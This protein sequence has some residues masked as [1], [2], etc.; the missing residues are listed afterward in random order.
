[1]RNA[2]RLALL[3]AF[4]VVA[5]CGGGDGNGPSDPVP[6]SLA[7]SGGNGQTGPV[8]TALPV[9][10][11][12]I[13]KD[14]RGNGIPGITVTFA[15]QAGGGTL[16]GAQV[17]TNQGG[18]AQVGS[19]I[20]GTASGAN[21]LSATVAGLTPIT[22]TATATAGPPAALV[23][24][25]APA[26][27]TANGATL[28][29]S[30]SVQVKD[31]FGNN[32]TQAGFMVTVAIA[33]GGGTLGGT[34]TVAT[35]ASGVAT[36]SNLTITGSVGVRTLSFSG[37]GV[38]ALL[39][40]NI[41]LTS[42]AAT[43][44]AA[45]TPTT[46]AGTAGAAVGSAVTVTATDQSGNPVAGAQV[47]FAVTAG[48]GSVTGASQTTDAS[49][50]A[51]L[52]SWTLGTVA[53]SLNTVSATLGALPP[54]VFSSTPTAAAPS[55]LLMV[56]EPGTIS[57]VN[58]SPLDPQPA[59]QVAD[60]FGNP[61]AQVVSVT[62]SLSGGGTLNGT[63]MLNTAADGSLSFSG[64]TVVGLNG[65]RTLGFSAPGLTGVTSAVFPITSGPA[66]TIAL[67]AGDGQSATVGTAVG[68]VPVVLITDQSGNP[69]G[70]EFVT[71]AITAGGGSI[72]GASAVS[73]EDGFAPLGSWTLG[74]TAGSNTLTA[75]ATGLSGSPI[76]FTATG[77]PAAASAL[78]L[79]TAPSSSATNG[80]PLAQQPAVQ[81]R[82]QFGN[83]VA[84]AGT[85]IAAS[86]S[87]G[88]G[89]VAG[90]TAAS[91]DAG[92]LASFSGLVVNGPVGNQQVLSFSGTGLS[93]VASG[94]INMVAG[95]AAQ[96]VITT[97]PSATAQSGAAFAQQP[98]LQVTDA[99]GNPVASVGV[100][101]TAA[102]ASGGGTL[103]GTTSANTDGAGT[104]TFTD[105]AISGL[106]GNRTLG[107]GASGLSGATSG[108]IAITAGA[109]ATIAAAS[110]TSQSATVGT[111]VATPPSVLVTDQSGNP[112]AGVAVTFAV[113]GGGGSLTGGNAV[114]DASGLAT[115]GSWT[116]GTTAGA[117]SL[118]ATSAG[119]AGSPV[120]FNATGTTA[121]PA[122]VAINAGDGQ[123]ATVGTAVAVAPSVAVT[124]QFG[125][126]VSGVTV[127]FAVTSGGGSVTLATPLTDAGGIATVG[128]WTLGTSV[129]QNTLSATVSGLPA[130]NFTATGTVGAATTLAISAG[131]GQAA[132]VNTAVAVQP[133]VQVTDQ[134]G[135]P[136]SG[137]AVTFAVASGGGS[138]TGGA[139]VTDAGGLAAVGSWTLG[140]VAGSNTLTATSAGLGGSP[141][142]FTA[143]GLAAAAATIALNGGDGQSATVGTA[144]ATDPSVLV[145]DQFGNPVSGVTVTF[146]VAG[147][148]GSVTGGTALSNALGVATVGSWTLGTTAGANSLTAT[149]A[150]LAGSP[151]TFNA[152]G[153]PAAASQLVI[154]TQPSASATNGAALAQQPVAQ[155]RDAFGNDVAQ[156]GVTVAATVATGSGTATGTSTALT[157]A[158]GVA[159]FSGLSITGLAGNYT[160]SLSATGLTSAT[161]SSIALSAGAAATLALNG[162]DNQTATVN[163]SVAIA[164]SVLVRDMSGNPV[165][166]VAVTFAIAGGGGSL[167]G[168]NAVSNASGIATVGSWTL[169]TAAGANS[170]TATSGTLSGSPV[171]FNATGTAGAATDITDNGGDGQ[172]GTAGSALATPLS[173]LVTDNFGNPVSGFTVTWATPSGGS[174]APVSTQT[175]ASGIASSTWTLGTAAGG[176]TASATGA[177]LSG[178]PVGYGATAL[179]GA[180]A[181]VAKTA[182][183][184]QTATV[185][186]AVAVDP[187]VLVTDQFGN[188]AAGVTVTFAVASGSGS[189]TGAT[190]STDGAGVATVGSW[191]LGTGAGGNT[192][193]ATVTGLPAATFSATGA[194]DAATTITLSAGDN[195][196]ATVNTAVA[197]NPEVVVTDQFGNPVSGVVVNF[198]V[199]AGGGSIAGASG[200]TDALG[201]ATGGSWTLGQTAGAN[202]LEA[203][204]G[205]LTGS[206]VIFT[207]TGTAGAATQLSITTQPSAA[208][209]SGAVLAQQPVLQLRDAFNN[210]V[211]QAGVSV[212][213]AASSGGTLAGTT[214]ASTSAGGQASFTDLALSGLAGNY[215]LS[216]SATGLTGATS[217][218]ITLSAGAAASISLN[219]G[220]NQ[221]ATV[222]NNV[223]VAPSVVV[224]DASNNP[225]SGVSVTF[226]VTGGGGSV[227]GSP[228]TTNASGIATVGSWRL[229]TTAGP[230]GLSA[231]SSGLSG[232]PVAFSATGVAGAAATVTAQSLTSQ[233][234]RLGIQATAAPS[235]LVRDAFNN[236][237][238]GQAVTFAVTAGGGSV[239]GGSATTDGLGIATVTGWTYGKTVV[240]NTVTATLGALPTVAFDA[241][242]S[243]VPASVAGGND[244]TCALTIDGI[245]YCWGQN[246]AGGLGDGSTSQ[247]LSPVAVTTTTSY[248][249]VAAGRGFSCGVE[250]GG[251]GRCWG[252][253]TFG[254]L[255]TGNTSPSSTPA[256][257]TG[258]L[259]LTVASAQSVGP[260]HHTCAI[261]SGAALFCWGDNSSAQFGR[262][263]FTP[264]T[265]SSPLASGGTGA[266]YTSV[267][268]G[269]K[270]T[271][272]VRTGGAGFCWGI[273]GF[274]QLGDG[275]TSSSPNPVAITGGLT[276]SQVATGQVHS[277][278]LTTGMDVY[279]W[280]FNLNGRVA[281][282]TVAFP[283]N[284]LTPTQVAGLSNVVQLVV[285]SAHTCALTSGNQVFCWG[286]NDAGQLGDNTTTNRPAATP[287]SLP[288]GVT[289]FS[290]ISAGASFTCG[291][292]TAN[293]LYCWGEGTGGQLGDG[294]GLDRSVPT[295]V[296]D[297]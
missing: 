260:N 238:A 270:F 248:T 287:I 27:A 56:T 106:V 144:V 59:V 49:G 180:P 263:S 220:N 277:C 58:G 227:T 293:K 7:V 236:P 179:A 153:T 221:T 63:T 52:G 39:S 95:A 209:A 271:C 291:V 33:T 273:N 99:G 102:I 274:G 186:S 137:V 32:S 24:I 77:T 225:V 132:T 141:A 19:W 198:N 13:V 89:S 285:G 108:T 80:V 261:T 55:R 257:V 57:A 265:S 195:Q 9:A 26:G 12:V 231:S 130:A 235:V 87:S 120:T 92:G 122:S 158:G 211:A 36:F 205:V 172:S 157:D 88:G 276:L 25:T 118:T 117:N 51:T 107:F 295:L 128:S 42:G 175:N 223:A 197:V 210:A 288:G 207:A 131:N 105:L 167:T 146:A 213:A 217:G 242:V 11:S 162:G 258:G 234:G 284:I 38:T 188:P 170:L 165:S 98:V 16:S 296:S 226:A 86:V 266:T 247:R 166:G 254:E 160:L 78:T 2:A 60:Q 244:H 124:D 17:V 156:A 127:T 230:N 35:N 259:T 65:M 20:L 196:T 142:T 104:A 264:A 279:C 50:Q 161:T 85:V 46:L 232:S 214:A 267:S 34:A 113:A 100:T 139:A 199:T 147:G 275:G 140:T 28:T 262:G 143:T 159:T 93:S 74:T 224:R 6:T 148:G 97:Q 10:P 204:S 243:F 185:N 240:T 8:A 222:D 173:V 45:A 212:T 246:A 250:T 151:V 111:A 138:L 289:G 171:T 119:L 252:N 90:N 152:V 1:M 192:L 206:P 114:T 182:G 187:E 286:L 3:V 72:T 168:A 23:F 123:S 193:T 154:I 61:V 70:G 228:A 216:F 129:G 81:L 43:A 218:T 290:A 66:T 110:T 101:V 283:G 22:F 219:A 115:V 47:T 75:T 149:S 294:A 177:G 245:P 292:T 190:Q 5:A 91:T 256:A 21:T 84:Q 163:S 253:N 272:G 203:S 278:G 71:Y 178:S 268:T 67:S 83:A 4:T 208:A 125:N 69:V 109:A 194:A 251:V 184:N 255:G 183:D 18:I 126:P 30:P 62:A 68:I 15:V 281:Q 269:D 29:P 164:P 174:L 79:A 134:F 249:A 96:L 239:T 282:D 31:Q 40:G 14:Q 145:R 48:G 181:S 191:T 112:V 155:L 135:N 37:T 150:G 76:T 201:H 73:D 241:T 54:V 82:D 200:A 116:L 53:G 229:G 103:G 44:L 94:P 233:N 297:P 215:T 136:V 280:G 64:L 121:P 176:Q 169:G 133:A 237:V 41:Q 189:V 202:T